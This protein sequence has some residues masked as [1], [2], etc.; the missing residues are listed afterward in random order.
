MSTTTITPLADTDWGGY[1]GLHPI[2]AEA[3]DTLITKNIEFHAGKATIKD[4][5]AAKVAVR[6][7]IT[8]CAD[9]EGA[10][11]RT[12]AVNMAREIDSL[13]QDCE[14]TIAILVTH[15]P[16]ETHKALREMEGR[17]S[18]IRTDAKALS[19]AATS[20]GGES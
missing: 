14:A 15:C 10:R 9:S 6:V 7:A 8:E 11:L 3:I 5:N 12:S 18:R 4:V 16:A 2:V 13:A 17:L 20:Q 1:A 19:S